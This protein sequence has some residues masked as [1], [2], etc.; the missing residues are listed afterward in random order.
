MRCICLEAYKFSASLLRG[1]SRIFPLPS[2]F[3]SVHTTRRFWIR[4]FPCFFNENSIIIRPSQTI[5]M[6]IN[7]AALA[8]LAT[9]AAA[10][11]LSAVDTI[12]SQVTKVTETAAAPGETWKAEPCVMPWGCTG[13]KDWDKHG[14]IFP[15]TAAAETTT[16]TL[17]TRIPIFTVPTNPVFELPPWATDVSTIRIITPTTTMTHAISVPTEASSVPT[18]TS[19]AGT[20]LPWKSWV[21]NPSASGFEGLSSLWLPMPTETRSDKSYA[22]TFAA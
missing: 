22:T 2:S 1:P 3:C 20:T 18:E 4:K 17:P 11:P 6:K 8:L 9:T 15:T 21:L 10:V 19:S 5:N 14:D 7:I 12:G 16:T 13:D